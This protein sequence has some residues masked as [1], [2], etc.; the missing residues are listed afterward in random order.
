VIYIHL[1]DGKTAIL[2][3]LH[4]YLERRRIGG[5]NDNGDT[6]NDTDMTLTK[7]A[8]V[9]PPSKVPHDNGL[10]ASDTEFKTVISYHQS[11]FR[12]CLAG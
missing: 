10:V 2:C 12:L 6:V 1:P 4:Q 5:L 8:L 7:T 9:H 11:L 3:I